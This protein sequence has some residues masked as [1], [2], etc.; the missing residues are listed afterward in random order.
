MT[1]LQSSVADLRDRRVAGFDAAALLE[2][3]EHLDP[4]RLPAFE[5]AVFG[6]ARPRTA[7]VM[8]TPTASTTR[9]SRRLARGTFRHPDHRFEWTRAEFGAWASGVAAAYG[10][11]VAFAPVGDADPVHGAPTQMAVFRCA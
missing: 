4:G 3:I 7:I 8:T 2:V 6:L 11:S 5:R 9:S 1:L 10:Y